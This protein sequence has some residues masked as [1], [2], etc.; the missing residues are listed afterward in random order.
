MVLN[1][2]NLVVLRKRP[3]ITQ[4]LKSYLIYSTL[5][6]YSAPCLHASGGVI[7]DPFTYLQS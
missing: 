6:K 5:P 4:A 7:N 3:H 1:S 2:L